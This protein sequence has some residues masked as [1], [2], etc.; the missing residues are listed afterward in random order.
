MSK[1]LRELILMHLVLLKGKKKG[2]RTL[3]ASSE[4]NLRIKD[5]IRESSL[6]ENMVKKENHGF[7]NPCH[8]LLNHPRKRM[9]NNLRALLKCLDLSF[10]AC[11]WL[12]CW[13]CPLML[14]IW[15]ILLRIKERYWK[16]KSP[17]WL[18]IIYLKV[19]YQRN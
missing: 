15:K 19:E 17:P 1:I 12:I 7:R 13:K 18:L 14:S 8:F 6:L 5:M 2:D 3:H 10:C 16:L 9:M 4:H 11:V